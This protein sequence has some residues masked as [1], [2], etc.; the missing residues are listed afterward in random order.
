MGKYM[1]DILLATDDFINYI[2]KTNDYKKYIKLKEMIL[3]NKEIMDLIGDVK[4]IQKKIVKDKYNKKDIS[5]LEKQ[6][7]DKIDKLENNPLYFEYD[8]I[9][10]DL[11]MVFQIIKEY[12]EKNIYEITN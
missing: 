6:L 8:S 9:Q 11:N 3:N 7:Q 2:K 10:K 5:D 12:I 1:N 4:T